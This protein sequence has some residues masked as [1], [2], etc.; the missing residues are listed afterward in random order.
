MAIYDFSKTEKSR[1]RTSP[2]PDYAEEHPA[3][4]QVKVVEKGR[5]F[6]AL[7]ARMLFMVLLIADLV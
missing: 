7:A 1:L 6:S 4:E 5:L 3:E 2:V